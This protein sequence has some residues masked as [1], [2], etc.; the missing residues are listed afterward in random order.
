MRLPLFAFLFCALPA[1]AYA[2]EPSTPVAENAITAP[3][4]DTVPTIQPGQE[5]DWAFETLSS[6]KS[7]ASEKNWG[8]FVSIL[9]MACLS[10]FS[11][12]FVRSKELR[13]KLRGYMPEVALGVSLL[14]YIGIALGTL[15]PGA[16]VGD[17]W[18][19][20]WPALKTG[21]AAVGAHQFLVKRLLKHW[22]PKL[23][24][25]VSKLWKKKEE[26]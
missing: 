18:G 16:S 22:G 1:L 15:Q 5:V 10:L 9:L 3:G 23:W 2:Q 8:L 6:L 20:I 11:L 14:G 13:D 25:L 19:V 4:G 21:L 26:K 7:A 12:I 24:A 17:W